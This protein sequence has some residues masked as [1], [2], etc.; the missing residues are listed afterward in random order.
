MS[1]A[2]AEVSHLGGPWMAHLSG[3]PA[4]DGNCLGVPLQCVSRKMVLWKPHSVWGT[5]R[6][7]GNSIFVQSP[8]TSG[9]KQPVRWRDAHRRLVF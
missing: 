4:G 9:R 3:H 7:D 1:A 8:P 2:M 6:M 5:P